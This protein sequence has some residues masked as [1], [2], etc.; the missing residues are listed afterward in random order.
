MQFKRAV[1]SDALKLYTEKLM[2]RTP[3]GACNDNGGTDCHSRLHISP[4]GSVGASA[5]QRC[6]PDTRTA[7][8]KKLVILNALRER[9]RNTIKG[10]CKLQAPFFLTKRL[11]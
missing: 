11:F 2:L 3:L 6:P 7:M 4:A 9:I 8:T 1:L 10:V 5:L